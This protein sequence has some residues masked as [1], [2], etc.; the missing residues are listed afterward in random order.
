MIF[1][2]A[3]VSDA[4]NHWSAKQPQV[5]IHLLES[6]RPLLPSFI[7]D[8]VLDQLI[9]PK[10]RQSIEEWDG[11]PSR[12]GKH[13]TLSG[14]VFP[15]LPILGHRLPDILEASKRKLRSFLRK[16]VVRDGVSDELTRWRKDVCDSRYT[17]YTADEIDL[18]QQGV[19][20]AHAPQCDSQAGYLLAR[21]LSSQ[22]STARDAAAQRL[23]PPLGRAHSLV[24][25]CATSRG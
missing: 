11:R 9:L 17:I 22:P 1:S 21:R 24:H 8:N 18:C 12:S 16:W 23:G 19:G 15:W 20:R 4:S 14:M 2:Q 3:C 10:L 6:W 13:R 5:A 25:I 7:M